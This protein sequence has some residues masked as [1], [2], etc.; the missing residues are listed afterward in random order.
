M[1][2]GFELRKL[3]L[4]PIGLTMILQCSPEKAVEETY[5][6]HDG[7]SGRGPLGSGLSPMWFDRPWIRK[8]INMLAM[9]KDVGK[10]GGREEERDS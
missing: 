8:E 10:P 3:S 6:S 7:V 1:E 9:S 4:M 2:I 5:I